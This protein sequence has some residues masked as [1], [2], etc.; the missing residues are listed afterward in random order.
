MCIYKTLKTAVRKSFVSR[1][2]TGTKKYRIYYVS[3]NTLKL[4]NTMHLL[5]YF[6]FAE[7]L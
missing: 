7:E 5:N 1:S 4:C 6:E 3:I 2:R